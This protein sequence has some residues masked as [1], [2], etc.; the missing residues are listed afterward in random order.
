MLLALKSPLFCVYMAK[1]SFLL[2]W[3]ISCI[4]LLSIFRV[5]LLK[6]CQHIIFFLTILIYYNFL[7]FNII[8]NYIWIWICHLI[9]YFF[10]NFL[11]FYEL[12]LFHF[13][14]YYCV[15][16]TSFYYFSVL[17]TLQHTFLL[18]QILLFYFCLFHYCCQ[19]F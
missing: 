6:I 16:Y 17:A 14:L 15:I 7:T 4:L 13:P 2:A 8:M 10:L 11:D 9:I 3:Y 12:F 1:S 5:L 18:I 19:A